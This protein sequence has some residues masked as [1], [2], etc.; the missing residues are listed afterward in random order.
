MIWYKLIEIKL[1]RTDY[2][3]SDEGKSF[4]STIGDSKKIIKLFIAIMKTL[5]TWYL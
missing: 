1:I 5:I 2:A 3:F 4:G